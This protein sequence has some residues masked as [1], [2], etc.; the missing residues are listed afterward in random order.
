MMFPIRSAAVRRASAVLL[1]FA[2]ASASA[3]TSA[4]NTSL[5]SSLNLSSS[6]QVYDVTGFA[7]GSSQFAVVCRG[8]SGADIVSTSTAPIVTIAHINPTPSN[9]NV[10]D[11][12]VWNGVLY[13][14]QSGGTIQRYDVSAPSVPVALTAFG[15]ATENI[16]VTNGLLYAARGSFGGGG[17]LEIW[18]ISGATP[19]LAS[20]YDN[21]SLFLCRDVT[22]KGN[23]AF[24]FNQITSS[25]Y[26]TV[27]FDVTN[28]ASPV[29][30]TTIVGGGQSGVAYHPPGDDVLLLACCTPGNS[31]ILQVFDVT[32][33]GTPPLLGSFQS[34]TNTAARNVRMLDTR[35]AA[36]AYYLDGL[37]IIDLGLPSQPIVAG[38][39]DPY[40]TNI[41]LPATQGFYGVYAESPTRIYATNT[42]TQVGV[43]QGLS[44]IDF[45]TPTPFFLTLTGAGTGGMTMNLK[46]APPNTLIINGISAPVVGGFGTGPVIGLGVD[47]LFIFYS[48]T[49]P[50][51]RDVTNAAG[52]YNVVVPP[53]SLP[54]G[55]ELAIRSLLYG[56]T[57]FEFSQ[58]GQIKF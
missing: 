58:L 25:N 16:F 7:I 24:A 32:G 22:A 44:V 13:L 40:P 21:G 49:W 39:Y 56:A 37:R 29:V 2:T 51:F 38:I 45:T 12:A 36:V 50:P 26:N 27:M 43:L 11:A 15:G 23:R 34:A 53:G 33:T 20:T 30:L 48:W 3:Q 54:P 35:Y 55:Y 9:A 41:G 42:V 1:C 19:T 17:A 6:N 5:F 14:A 4:V 57:T 46:G 31:G 28:P 47:A 10:V 52:E 18:N 8:T